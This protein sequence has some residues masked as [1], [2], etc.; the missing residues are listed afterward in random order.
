MRT[1]SRVLSL[2]SQPREEPS[3]GERA[4]LDSNLRK[5]TLAKK[6]TTG[7]CAMRGVTRPR[8]GGG[9]QRDRGMT[10]SK[11]GEHGVMFARC[12]C[13]GSGHVHQS[14]SLPSAVHVRPPRVV[15]VFFLSRENLFCIVLFFIFPL[16][17]SIF[18]RYLFYKCYFNNFFFFL[19]KYCDEA[20]R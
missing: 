20:R 13:S 2:E 10:T 19:Y 3:T 5:N 4:V 9:P 6:H 16:P 12:C 8:G 15:F 1:R 18:H 14:R 17:A 7:Y 11:H